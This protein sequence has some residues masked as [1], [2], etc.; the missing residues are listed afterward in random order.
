MAGTTFLVTSDFEL[1]SAAKTKVQSNEA[2]MDLELPEVESLGKAEEQVKLSNTKKTIILQERNT[3]VM[4]GP[5][6]DQSVAK[7]QQE[8]NIMSHKLKKRDKIYLIMDTPGG[9][10]FAGMQLIDHL[11]AIPQ[12]VETITLFAASMGFQIVQNM[13]NRFITPSGTLMS[14]RASGGLRGQFDGELE[15]RYQMVKRKIDYLDAIAAKRMD[16]G[17]K[18]YKAMI[19]DEY[20][21]SGFD[22]PIQ[23]AADETVNVRCGETM[24]GTKNLTVRTIFG[25]A[26]VKL[27]KCPIITGILGVD[28]NGLTGKNKTEVSNIV[29]KGF[30]NQR[31]YVKDYVITGKHYKVFR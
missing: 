5:V 8:L 22:A 1:K 16:M 7:L 15:T 26:N 25:S 31:Q 13:D 11:R 10:V 23:K 27:S 20:W 14:H 21:V 2:V 30:V 18:D 24:K 19:K 3:L 6:T 4:K 29:D 9:S 12:K 28:F 17:V